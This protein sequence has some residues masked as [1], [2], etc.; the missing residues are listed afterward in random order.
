MRTVFGR[1]G[2]KHSV[3]MPTRAG[4]RV[5]RPLLFG[6]ALLIAM[7]IPAGT[8]LA[9]TPTVGQ[10]FNPASPQPIGTTVTDNVL[11]AGATGN[12]NGTILVKRFNTAGDCNNFF[13][14]T[15][16]QIGATGNGQVQ[17]NGNWPIQFTAQPLGAFIIGARFISNNADNTDSAP[18]CDSFTITQATPT[19]TTNATPNSVTIGQNAHDTAHVG[20]GF[21]PTGT[22][23]FSLFT[24]DSCDPGGLIFQ[25]TQ[26]I[27]GSGDAA[28][29]DFP[30]NTVGTH[31]WVARYNGDANNNPVATGCHDPGEKLTVLDKVTPV[32]TTQ[33]SS[34]SVAFGQPIHDTVHVSNNA[35]G[36]VTFR[37]FQDNTCTTPAS[38]NLGPVALDGSS[39]ATSP[40]FTPGASNVPGA[41]YWVAF[42]GGD[43]LNKPAASG[44]GDATERFVI[45]KATPTIATQASPDCA[46]T[47]SNSFNGCTLSDT[48]TL[49]GGFQPTGTV[50]FR[51]WK[52][53][54]SCSG[55]PLSTLGPVALAGNPPSATS[56]G[57]APTLP[58]PSSPDSYRWTAEYSGD[59]FNNGVTTAC[60]DPNEL[61]QTTGP[62]CNGQGSRIWSIS[63]NKIINGT[64]GPDVI[65]AG[66]GAQTVNGLG[67]DDSICGG[68]GDDTLNGD[69]GDDT[70]F[71]DSGNDKIDGGAGANN[72]CFGGSG[73]DTFANCQSFTQKRAGSPSHKHGGKGGNGNRKHGKHKG[74]VSH[75]R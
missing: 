41:H 31:W 44:C 30:T 17:S 69:G 28:S 32:V 58:A 8:A 40:D 13:N 21:N 38:P 14:T 18:Q 27:D 56:P 25:N 5:R 51:V 6:A 4:N 70:I 36:S 67:G 73:V 55:P 2:R 52:N 33:T 47:I 20:G 66:S 39:N 23:T 11:M 57:I 63:G 3:A 50:V 43:A 74:R 12:I 54:A 49:S 68:S 71:G 16:Q 62:V 1:S 65:Y 48:A 9:A 64:A 75:R 10:S 60:N 35:T 46:L 26:P 19:L 29:N 34:T 59:A 15:G 45:Q 7:A 24:N 42:Y 53:N 22:V 37:V 72:T 61:N